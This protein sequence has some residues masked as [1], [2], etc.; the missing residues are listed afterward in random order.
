MLDEKIDRRNFIK[1]MNSATATLSL[2]GCKFTKADKILPYVKTPENLIPGNPVF[3][4]TTLLHHGLGRGVLVETHEARPTKI[5]G[6]PHHPASLGAADL[7]MQASILQLYDPDRAQDFK[8]N[9]KKSSSDE[10]SSALRTEL[11]SLQEK[12]GE[13]LAILTSSTSSPTS[14]RLIDDILKKNPKASWY[15][16]DPDSECDHRKAT[17]LA[18]GNALNVFYDFKKADRIVSFD[19]DFLFSEAGSLAYAREYAAK[20]GTEGNILKNGDKNQ[21][22]NR[23]YMFEPSKSLTGA[24]ADHHFSANLTKLRATLYKL[25]EILG[26][27]KP[28]TSLTSI[29]ETEELKIIDEIALDLKKHLGRSLIIAGKSLA[30]VDQAL[31]HA[32]NLKLENVN[33]TVLF[34]PEFHSISERPK[35]LKSLVDRIEKGLISHLF[36]L[37]SNPIYS[38]P[39]DLVFEKIMAKVPFTAA[40]SLYE[41]ET[42]KLVNWHIPSHHVLESWGD[43][44]S[45]EGTASLIQPVIKPLYKTWSICAFLNLLAGHDEIEELQI[46]KATWRTKLGNDFESLWRKALHNGTIAGSQITALTPKVKPLYSEFST[47]LSSSKGRFE[48][49]FRSDLCI[50]D[51]SFA[52]NPWLQETPKPFSKL[53]WENAVSLASLDAERLKIKQ[54]VLVKISQGER[55]VV[56]PAILNSGQAVGTILLSLGYG[57]TAAGHIG[58]NLGYNANALRH[59]DSLWVEDGMDLEVLAESKKLAI[60]QQHHSLAGFEPAKIFFSAGELPIEPEKIEDSPSIYPQKKRGESPQWAMA[61]DLNRCLGCNACVTACQSEN[62][63]PTVG[64]DEVLAGREMHWIRIDQYEKVKDKKTHLIHQPVPCM[65]CEQ[66]PCEKVCPVGATTHSHEGLNQMVYNRCVGTRYCSNNCPYKV[67]RFNFFNYGENLSP[68]TEL[69]LNP[70]VTVRGG[71]VMEKCTYCVQRIKETQIKA[72][73]KNETIKDGDV[74]PACQQTC[75]TQAIVFGDLSDP[76]SRISRIKAEPRNYHLM[77]ELNARPRTSYLARSQNLNTRLNHDAGNADDD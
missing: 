72:D 42:A 31:V 26:V 36:I 24:M 41:D 67:R 48:V 13:G 75:P 74:V 22:A 73:I 64:K 37:E 5:E 57:R 2:T 40:I 61:I 39:K 45:F 3:Y 53:T 38:S 54:G 69:Q 29:L 68:V 15:N 19:A 47:S 76:E 34:Y 23:L 16:W 66:A 25:G 71:G 9:G 59:I 58:N 20:R 62:N 21:L 44:C 6:N 77:K 8:H 56:G 63:I 70:D 50:G 33:Q 46:V 17:E 49:F 32:L 12:N 51:G 1:L 60:T 65:H 30:S 10:F 52:N 35:T 27:V 11:I 43:A 55:S 14:L 4:A 18:F 7:F 28:D